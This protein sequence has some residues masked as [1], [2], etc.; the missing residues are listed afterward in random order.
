MRFSP[1]WCRLTILSTARSGFG[2]GASHEATVLQWLGDE[3]RLNE[4]VE[5]DDDTHNLEDERLLDSRASVMF[6][7]CS[8]GPKVATTSSLAASQHVAVKSDSAFQWLCRMLRKFLIFGRGTC[9]VAISGRA[10]LSARDLGTSV[11]VCIGW[12]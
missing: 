7:S 9:E 11:C 5:R 12:Y 2:L 6:E 8:V 10:S 4:T 1:K 3:V